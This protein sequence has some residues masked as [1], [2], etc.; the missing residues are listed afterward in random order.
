MKFKVQIRESLDALGVSEEASAETFKLKKPAQVQ[1]SDQ[2]DFRRQ[3]YLLFSDLLTA[4]QTNS[5]SQASQPTS[6]QLRA[7]SQMR[8]SAGPLQAIC[9]TVATDSFKTLRN[10]CLKQEE[11]KGEEPLT[12]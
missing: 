8:N 10:R 7:L 1:I 11:A 2:S 4:S 9:L 3:V 6:T 5:G 12:E